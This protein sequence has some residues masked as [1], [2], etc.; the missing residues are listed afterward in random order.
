MFRA[1]FLSLFRKLRH[2]VERHHRS[3]LSSRAFFITGQRR[4][5]QQWQTLVVLYS[6]TKMVVRCLAHLLLTDVVG[7]DNSCLKVGAKLGRCSKNLHRLASKYEPAGRDHTPLG[8]LPISHRPRS[9]QPHTIGPLVMPGEYRPIVSRRGRLPRQMEAHGALRAMCELW[10]VDRRV[11]RASVG[12][13]VIAC[14]C[15]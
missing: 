2:W 8:P 13:W 3:P 14:R 11:R 15:G 4:T 12:Q 9:P 6:S 10:P 5:S 7:V 1:A